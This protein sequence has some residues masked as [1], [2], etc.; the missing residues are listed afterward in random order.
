MTARRSA[1][2]A[3]VALVGLLLVFLSLPG[4]LSRSAI[5]CDG[6]YPAWYPAENGCSEIPS[7]IE[8][9]WPPERWDAPRACEAMCT[10]TMAR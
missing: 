1:T 10:G 3:G 6:S 2:L 5:M 7:L 8:H 4:V 9:L